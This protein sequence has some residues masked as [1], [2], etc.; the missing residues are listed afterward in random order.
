M[1]R[2][3]LCLSICL[4][5]SETRSTTQMNAIEFTEKIEIFSSEF[6]FRV[7]KTCANLSAFYHDWTQK[8]KVFSLIFFSRIFSVKYDNNLN[9]F[10]VQSLRRFK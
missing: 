2:R 10:V 4:C 6:F 5:L 7:E 8:S 3:K 9:D 1:E